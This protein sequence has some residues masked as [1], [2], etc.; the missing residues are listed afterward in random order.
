MQI[1]ARVALKRKDIIE[2]MTHYDAFPPTPTRNPC[3][4]IV[5]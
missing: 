1:V 2:R 5:C 3:I 4:G